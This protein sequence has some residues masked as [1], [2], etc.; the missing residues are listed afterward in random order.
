MDD[1]KITVFLKDKNNLVANVTLS[2]NTI[3]YG[4]ITIKDFQIWKSKNFN[5]R[6]QEPINISPP[7][8]NV[9]GR[10]LPTVFLERKEKWYEIESKIYDAYNLAKIEM[11]AKKGTS[12]INLDEITGK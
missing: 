7:T 11:L 12:D 4:F 10:Y 8:R 9:Y 3:A 2:F 5:E 6:L 1:L